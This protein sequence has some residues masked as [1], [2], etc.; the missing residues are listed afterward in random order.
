MCTSKEAEAAKKFWVSDAAGDTFNYPWEAAA[1]YA[2]SKVDK[3]LD[4]IA[5]RRNY[6]LE[7][8]REQ[9]DLVAKYAARHD[10]ESNKALSDASGAANWHNFAENSLM[11]L[12]GQVDR[13][14]LKP[15]A[16]VAF[17]PNGVTIDSPTSKDC[18]PV[19][20]QR[21]RT[22]GRSK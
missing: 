20:K 5:A 12:L 9:L 17:G 21:L 16:I 19:G 15:G 4:A 6:H 1:D 13:S 22:A 14:Q 11:V 8:A 2:A 18:L 10:P 7:N 3:I